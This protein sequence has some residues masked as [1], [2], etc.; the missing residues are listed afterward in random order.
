MK[1]SEHLGELERRLINRYQGGFPLAGRPFARVAAELDCDE[2]LLK[3]T[4]QRLLD[5]GWISRFGPLYNAARMG[6]GLVLAALEAPE[7]RFAEIA[8]QVNT[9]PEVAHN[10][11][12]EH[13]LNMWFVLATATPEGITEATGRIEELTG[14]RVFSFPKEREFYLGLWLELD[15]EGGCRTRSLAEL[16]LGAEA[17]LDD[18]DRRIV[19]ATQSGLPL[20]TEPCA[21]VAEQLGCQ[22]ADVIGRLEAMLR[23][24]A[25][26]RVGLVPNHYRLGLR[27]NGMTVW[28]IP[29]ER[30]ESVGNSIGAL[31]FVSHCYTR[32]RHAPRWPY[33]LFAMVHGRG[34]QEVEA[35]V[36]EMAHRIRGDSRGHDVLFSTAVLKKTGMRLV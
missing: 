3:N 29:D 19:T 21:S 14:C 35:K 22:A 1:D 16:P 18:L 8:E 17:P 33:N 28:D 11:R 31:D 26:R 10:Y 36:E 9:L 24:G 23:S 4:V 34:R 25:I 30:T 20:T 12:R 6:G 15:A 27:G 7:D 2:T 13:R 32:P 5:E